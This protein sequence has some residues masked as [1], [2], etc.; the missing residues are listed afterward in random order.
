MAASK[1]GAKKKTAAKSRA[2]RK[3]MPR[4]QKADT[5]GLDPS[6]CLLDKGEASLIQLEK[7]VESEG[8]VVVG[9]YKD[10][11]GGHPMLMTVLPV[12]KIEPT[13]FQRDLSDTHHKRL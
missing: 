7:I 12:G 2:P 3:V 8:G 10:P 5:A 4:K 9:R 11:L 6:S 13:P 1:A